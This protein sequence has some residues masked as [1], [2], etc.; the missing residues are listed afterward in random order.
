M[1]PDLGLAKI[2]VSILGSN[3]K[4]EIVTRLNNRK[5]E[6]RGILGNRIGKQVRIIPDIRFYLDD[7]LDRVDKMDQIFKDLNIPPDNE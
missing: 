3:D 5:S 4:E 2:Y 6:V 1:T 7:S